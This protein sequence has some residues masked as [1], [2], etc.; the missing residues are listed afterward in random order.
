MRPE[1]PH[2]RGPL[3]VHPSWTPEAIRT[4]RAVREDRME[5]RAQGG[6]RDM[7]P[8]T[9]CTETLLALKAPQEVGTPASFILLTNMLSDLSLFLWPCLM[10]DLQEG[11][12]YD[13]WV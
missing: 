11:V 13:S 9:E 2:E 10:G 8:E 12:V 7:Q 1:P 6:A 5:R 4:V 3:A